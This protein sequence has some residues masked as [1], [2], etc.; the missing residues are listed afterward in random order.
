M[1]EEVGV[2]V[3]LFLWWLLYLLF[4]ISNYGTFKSCF[5]KKAFDKAFEFA[6]SISSNV[7]HLPKLHG[8]MPT[9]E[10]SQMG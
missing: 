7:V 8:R 10:K 3:V 1:E 5:S 6:F 9:I 2:D 4:V